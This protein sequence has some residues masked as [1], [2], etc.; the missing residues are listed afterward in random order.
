MIPMNPPHIEASIARCRVI[1]SLTA[2]LAIFLDPTRPMVSD[3]ISLASGRFTI[4]AHVL[5]LMGAHLLYSVVTYW[6]IERR[7][8][9]PLRL[10]A[11]TTWIDVFF[12]AAIAFW[13]E[14][15]TSPFY[16]FFAFAVLVAGFRAGLRHTLV[17]MG[18]SVLLYLCLIL[19]SAPGSA[20]FYIMRPVYLAITGYLV[21]YLGQQRLDLQEE[22]RQLEASAERSRIAR[23]LHDGFVQSLAG[24]DLRIESSRLSLQKGQQA[25]AL[26][27]LTD[28]QRGVSREYDRLRAYMRSLAGVEVTP[29]SGRA[30]AK[31]ELAVNA[32]VSG[33]LELIDHV[34]QI[35]RE[36]VSNVRRH[37]QAT[38][39]KIAI[40]SADSQ[41]SMLIEDDGIGLPDDATPWSI[42]SRVEDLGG[43][44]QVSRELRQGTRFAITL[45]RR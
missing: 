6:G 18:A 28:L 12:G 1:L 20:N 21:G 27:E 10:A 34:L 19:V 3:W 42:A 23:D 29:T 25:E 14:G 24:I 41:V 44:I 8:F 17:V 11:A 2:L 31:T 39:A 35:A 9:S 45:P 5:T 22:L 38:S 40:S 15:A 13:T 4:D 7:R 16:P 37:A 26:S 43:Q 33:S 36:G 30:A 32:H